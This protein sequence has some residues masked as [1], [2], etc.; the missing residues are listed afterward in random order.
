MVTRPV[1]ILALP[2]KLHELFD[3]RVPPGAIGDPDQK[4][5][6]F[7]SRA[8]SAYAL[9]K[10]GGASIEDAAN[11]IVDGGGDGGIDGIYFSPVT[12][13]L[14]LSQSKYI[15]A[16]SGEPDLGE[17]T[18]F[19]IGI[20][21]LLEARF[22]AF[23][24]NAKIV[25]LLPQLEAAL[26]N[27]STQVR[28]VLC[29][30]G[31][32][33]ISEDRKHL[34]EALR[35]KLSLDQ[36]DGYFGFQ[37]VNLTTLND[38]VSGGDAAPGIETVELEII[39]PGYVTAPYETIYGLIP[40]ERLK[41]LHDEHGAR[42]VRANIRGFK[43]STDVNEDIQKTLT[44]EAGLFHYLNNGLTAY[45]DRLEL[46]NL[47]RANAERKRITAKGFAIINGAQTLGSIAKCV[48]VPAAEAPPQGF[49][50]IKIVSLEKCEDDRA[51][52]DRI[53]RTAN[54]Q[55]TVVLK[56]F[57]AAY[58][59]HGQIAATLQPHGIDYHYRLDED[60]PANDA[61]NF[62]ID[63]ALTACACLG[64]TGDCDLVTRVAANR[65]SLL[66][67]DVV[68]PNDLLCP[69]RHERVFPQGLSARTA[70]R[71]VQAQ[72]IVLLG[73]AES[74]RASTGVTK[75]FYTHAR[76][77]V[78]AAVYI[79]LK[80][81]DGEALGLTDD[82]AAAI[83]AAVPDYAEKLLAIAVGKGF[84][85][86]ADVGGQQILQ[87]PRDFQSV[88]KTQGDCRNL[89]AALKAELWNPQNQAAPA[90][91]APRGDNV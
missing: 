14:W 28:S 16:G 7:L 48:A 83:A 30:S 60:T 6:D 35:V 20:E 29:Y 34:F 68:Y 66:S 80:P 91:A 23:V 87:S 42:L 58:P 85:A 4:E 55:N 65:S 77:A 89:F 33:F 38:W 57:A 2:P 56:D 45:C 37:A 62:T 50:F 9:H 25:A 75:S 39:R 11:G 46:H 73:M 12:N 47:D 5:R 90:M 52:A 61:R 59:L 31:L 15:H 10:L 88:F 40:L 43:G 27:P 44:D 22:D 79:R 64:N 63:E 86:Y 84:A 70:W 19:K 18:K 41:V 8:L 74:A 1:E 78:L 82:E 36:A 21:N 71:A 67:L 24:Q 17:V 32:S 3:G 26:K 72:R 81:Q 69:S 54:F 49:A 51:F 53:S 76:W 13:T